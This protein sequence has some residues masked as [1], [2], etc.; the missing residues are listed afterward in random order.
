MTKF[1]SGRY[2]TAEECDKIQSLLKEAYIDEC[3]SYYTA[4]SRPVDND[5]FVAAYNDFISERLRQM[6]R[7]EKAA[8][9]VGGIDTKRI[10]SDVRNLVKV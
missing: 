4:K 9:A 10:V 5:R 3:V 6:D 8:E 1:V 7:I 2:L